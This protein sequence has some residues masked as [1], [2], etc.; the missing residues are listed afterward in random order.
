MRTHLETIDKR[1]IAQ[2][3]NKQKNV[4]ETKQ[5]TAKALQTTE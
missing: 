1:I 5:I 4:L 2:I 3:L